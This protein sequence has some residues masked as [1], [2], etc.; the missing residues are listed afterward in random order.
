M[1]FQ[2]CIQSQTCSSDA[3][4]DVKIYMTVFFYNLCNRHGISLL[5]S[6][7]ISSL[8]PVVSENFS[9]SRSVLAFELD[10][11]EDDRPFRL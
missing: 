2:I 7:E 5:L 6:E 9:P 1:F 11:E 10:A 4:E 3:R 8:L